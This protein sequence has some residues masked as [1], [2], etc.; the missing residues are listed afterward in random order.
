MIE[1]L[2]LFER[3]PTEIRILRVT[4]YIQTSSTRRTTKIPSEFY[5]V[6][7]IASDLEMDKKVRRKTN[8]FD[9]GRRNLIAIDETVI[10]VNKNRY[11]V[12]LDVNS[13]IL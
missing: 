3:I 13:A 7:H 4:T 5:P 12:S 1:E 6:S 11:Y 9:R 8:D 10:K 2:N